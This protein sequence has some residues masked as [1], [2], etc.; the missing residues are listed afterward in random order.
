MK[1]YLLKST[2]AEHSMGLFSKWRA[3]LTGPLIYIGAGARHEKIGKTYFLLK[4]LICF[5]SNW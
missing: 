4:S 3:F 5:V 2:S 1:I